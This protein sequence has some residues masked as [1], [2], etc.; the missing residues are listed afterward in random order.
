MLLATA[1]PARAGEPS[2]DPGPVELKQKTAEAFDR[3]VQLTE[4]RHDEELR[5]GTPFLWIDALPEAQHQAAYAE[6]RAGQVKMERLETRDAGRPIRCPGGLIHHWVGV[7]FVPGV[8]LPQTL[9]LLQD[10]D[11]HST[12]YKPDVQRSKVLERHGNDFKVFLRFRR[13]KIITVVLNTEH[14]IHYF[15]MEAAHAHSR[16]RTT[17]IAEV[18]NHDQP[19]EREKPVGN[20]GGYLWRMNTYWRFLERGGGTY[21][22]CEAITLTREIPLGLRWLIRPFVTSIP[23]ETLT[24]T[25]TATRKALES[26]AASAK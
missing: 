3:Y 18:E 13:R 10:Y 2:P 9:R 26:K 1:G 14:E 11:H 21:V 23:R 4:A 6:L 24:G 20:D 16:S 7:I 5:R 8:T 22:Q 25:L 17:R 15:P 12:Y 19:D